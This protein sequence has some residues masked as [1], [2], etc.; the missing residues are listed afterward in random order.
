MNRLLDVSSENGFEFEQY[1]EYIFKK[2]IDD[3][4][5][6]HISN[7]IHPI[8]DKIVE[9]VN[10]PDIGSHLVTPRSIY[11]HHGIYVGNKKIIQYSG[12]S[13]EEFNTDD[14]VPLN[15]HN[16]SSIEIVTIQDFL[17]GEEYWIEEHPYSSYSNEEIVQRAYQRLEEKEYNLL[18]NNCE[19]FA[20]WCIY[21]T[22]H[23]KQV[24]NAK[25][26]VGRVAKP[27]KMAVDISHIAKYMKEYIEGKISGAKLLNEIAN[28]S[29]ASASSFYYGIAGQ[30]LIPI[31]VIG[32]VAGSIAGYFIGNLLYNSGLFSIT[33]DSIIVKQAKV[34][35][36]KIE[37]I[38]KIMLP[39]MQE[40]RF[41]LE[42]Y[43]EKY[44]SDRKQ[45]F[46]TSFNEFD[47]AN[48]KNDPT[49]ISKSLEKIMK[50]FGHELTY[51]TYDDFDKWLMS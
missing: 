27:L 23:S 41:R 24:E 35:R 42:K 39:I 19:H 2:N 43:M 4:L 18:F 9:F 33:G 26:I 37:K 11:T 7:E 47:V 10:L 44:F 40:N 8:T 12:F 3:F 6:G 22:E 20:N 1:Q 16:R 45:I 17:Q 28:V 46:E 14:I 13:G 48:E 30:T 34:R 36:E 29:T 31:P 51:K 15:V 25:R 50:Q 21:G 49:M 38:S 32:F 5:K